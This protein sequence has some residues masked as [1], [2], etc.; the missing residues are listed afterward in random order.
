[1]RKA[2]LINQQHNFGLSAETVRLLREEA[3][4]EHELHDIAFWLIDASNDMR[5][6]YDVISKLRN[7]LLPDIY[8]RPIVAIVKQGQDRLA[9]TD[10]LINEQHVND[11]KINELVS[12]YEPVNQWIDK[13]NQQSD[14]PDYGYV[15]RILRMIVSRNMELA[16]QSGIEKSMGYTYPLV[17]AIAGEDEN[18]MFHALE[19]L[20]HQR[21]ISGR[22]VTKAHFCAHCDCAF[23]NFK[24]ACPQCHSED[25][26][27]QQ[28]IHHFKCSYVGEE[29]EYQK[30]NA[31]VCP[32]CDRALKHIGVDFDKPSV[33]HRCNQ[34]NNRFQEAIVLTEC[35]NCGRTS[36]PE[37]QRKRSI[38]AFKSTA[39]GG[40]A[41]I[42]GMDSLFK[43][44]MEPRF[45]L[46]SAAEF[47]NILQ[48]EIARIARYQRSDS[49][50]VLINFDVETI[51]VKFGSQAQELFAEI[52]EVFNSLLRTS[53]V[54]SSYNE[55]LFVILLI[56]TSTDNA[57][58][59]LERFKVG[60]N[61]LLA[62]N[63]GDDMKLSSAIEAV[64]FETDLDKS[65]EQFLAP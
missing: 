63:I 36:E 53:D 31:L 28:L 35:F 48:L 24:E 15:F 13:A 41:A 52:S 16:P 37:H 38:K 44:V 47:R 64:T 29:Q 17:D 61:E 26:D 14:Q 59:A 6:A 56:E 30:D 33:I 39:M 12:R 10:L 3:I 23:M 49:S 18:S 21:L 2:Y 1:M 54:I 32:K 22:F 55:S 50:L 11:D 42:Y 19:M 5:S 40:N 45:N 62:H 46:F 25:I 51:Y 4:F 57:Q 60:V 43:Q 8:L 9:G 65:V 20:E 34:C 27:S 58:I 7:Q